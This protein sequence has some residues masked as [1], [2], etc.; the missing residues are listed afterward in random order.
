MTFRHTYHWVVSCLPPLKF[1][2]F[3]LILVTD[4]G[5]VDITARLVVRKEVNVVEVVGIAG[6]VFVVVERGVIT[7]VVVANGTVIRFWGVTYF[8]LG[9]EV[10]LTAELVVEGVVNEVTLTGITRII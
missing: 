10:V 2:F 5:D 8:V 6:V 1:A 3:D 7:F 4:I 9:F